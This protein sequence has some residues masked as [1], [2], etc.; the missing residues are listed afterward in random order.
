MERGTIKNAVVTGG[1]WL[2]CL[3][4]FFSLLIP[5]PSAVFMLSFLAVTSAV[6]PLSF[7]NAK[8]R[9]AAAVVLLVAVLTAGS[10]VDKAKEEKYFKSRQK[11]AS[12]S[13]FQ[14]P[15]QY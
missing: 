5:A 8:Q 10:M 13:V 2:S 9:I 1:L 3:L 6:F 15:R 14:L 12:F 4:V 11:Q 7:G